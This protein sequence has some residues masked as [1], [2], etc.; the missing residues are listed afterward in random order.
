M[1]FEKE[2]VK[3]L[4]SWKKNKPQGPLH[5]DLEPTASCN[6]KCLFC[7]TRVKE[8]VESC[9]YERT[10]TN[11]RLLEIVKEAAELKVKEWEIAGGW[12]P[13]VKPR[14]VSKV[15]LLIKENGMFGSITTNGTLFTKRMI[16]KLVEAEW[17][18]ILFSVE[19]P[20][21]EIHDYLTQTPGSFEKV[22]RNIKLFKKYKEIL[23]KDK[24]KY[25]IHAVLT[26]KNYDKLEAMIKL[27][28]ELGCEGVNFEPLIVWS[29]E[30]GKLSLNEKQKKELDKHIKNALKLAREL[31]VYTNVENLKRKE[32]V[33]KK[34][35][36]KI[37]KRK[38]KCDGKNIFSAPCFSPW[39]N[40]EIRVS[41]R[42]TY[43]RLCNDET[44]CDNILDKSLKEIWFGE[45]FERARKDFMYG[46]LPEFCKHCASGVI[47][48]MDRLRKKLSTP[49]WGWKHG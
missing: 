5:I 6:L 47:V 4:K 45:Y 19:G 26:N 40:M 2:A 28:K 48:E 32:L 33:L 18:R 42:V 20:N 46:K 49:F 16:R 3:R 35:M 9:R 29:K 37:L 30:I 10:L 1:Q 13:L 39:L 25:S 36:R 7:W 24:P 8:K 21:A 43:C 31:G 41:G 11:K 27:G 12:E 23:G 44:G 22:I 14:I 17:D 15:M 34:D 38:A